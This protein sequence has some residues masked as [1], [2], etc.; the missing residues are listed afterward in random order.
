MWLENQKKKCKATSMKIFS[1]LIPI[2][3]TSNFVHAG[4]FDSCQ[5]A[6]PQWFECKAN[7]DCVTITNPCGHPTAAVNKKYADKAQRCNITAGAALSCAS[8]TEGMPG[9]DPVCE[10]KICIGKK[11]AIKKK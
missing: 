3:L 2:L 11:K 9:T 6:N 5:K 4:A 10:A 8:W 1:I 7:E